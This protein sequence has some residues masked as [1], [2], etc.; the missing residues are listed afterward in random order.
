MEPISPAALNNRIVG[1]GV[2]TLRREVCHDVQPAFV[3]FDL[4]SGRTVGFLMDRA[5]P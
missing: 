3:G 5:G 2:G 1:T 4:G